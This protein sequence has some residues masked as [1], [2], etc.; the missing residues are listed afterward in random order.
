MKSISHQIGARLLLSAGFAALIAGPALAD[1]SAPK[2]EE[3]IVTAQ[4]R[5]Q[6]MQTVGIAVSAVG[7]QQLASL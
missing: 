5:A 6:N 3:V 2:L 7:A 4:K 1:A